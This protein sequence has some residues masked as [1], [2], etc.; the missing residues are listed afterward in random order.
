MPKIDFTKPAQK[1][2]H[3]R[4]VQLVEKM[5]STKQKLAAATNETD[6]EFYENQAAGWDRQIDD[7]ACDLY[8]LTAEERTLVRGD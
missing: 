1:A 7:L 8:G 3:D 2:Q 4:M 5:L 6:R